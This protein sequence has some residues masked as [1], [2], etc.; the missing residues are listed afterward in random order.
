MTITTISPKR[1]FDLTQSGTPV[2]LID[3]RKG[4]FKFASAS[5]F[6]S[7]LAALDVERNADKY[8]GVLEVMPE[9]R[10]AEIQLTKNQSFKDLKKWFGGDLE[11]ARVLNPHVTEGVWKGS[12][13]LS[14][15]HILRVPLMQ[16]SQARAELQ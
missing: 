15:R 3:V 7:F 16:E 2:E 12:A 1:L 4:R 9:L 13:P 14:R 11:L 10:G 8:F 6:A 5:F